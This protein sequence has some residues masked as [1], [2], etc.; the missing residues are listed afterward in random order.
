M[1]RE[2]LS[3]EQAEYEARR[4]FGDYD[5]YRQQARHID[6]TML[7][8]RHRMELFET[9]RRETRHAARALLRAPSFSVITIVTLA[10]GL[11]AAT[12]I[13]TLLDRVVIRPLPYPNAERMLHIGTLWPKVK[14]D[15]E[16]AISKGQYFYFKKNSTTL[17][18]MLAVRRRHGGHSGR[19][20]PSAGAR[21]DAH[22]ERE[23]VRHAW[24][25][26]RAGPTCSPPTWSSPQ[27]PTVALHQSRILAASVRR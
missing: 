12:T 13:F 20:R 25:S 5:A 22:G 17:A 14:A 9:L 10:L 15:A 18:D 26:P 2:H 21:P 3:R 23:H 16:Y 7:I 11:G 1:E 24:H 8:R 27:D 4:R 19:R 6:D